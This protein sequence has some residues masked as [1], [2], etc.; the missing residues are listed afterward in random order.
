LPREAAFHYGRLRSLERCADLVLGVNIALGEQQLT[1]CPV[2]DDDGTGSVEVYELITGVN[3]ALSGCP[4]AALRRPS[5]SSTVALSDDESV[6]VMA[7][8]DGDAVSI[9]NTSDNTKIATVP[10]GNEPSSVVILPDNS[11]ALVANRAD[12]TV[13]VVSNIKSASAAVTATVDVGSEPTGLALSPTGTRVF[14]AEWAEGRVSVLDTRDLSTIATIDSPEHPRGLVVTNDGDT[15]DVD[16]T[17]IVSEFFGAVNP[18]IAGCPTNNAEGCDTGRTG[19]LRRFNVGNYQ[20]Q[21]AIGLQPFDSGFVPAGSAAGTPTVQTAPN[22]L[23]GLAILGSKVFVTSVSA[24]PQGPIN[25][26]ANVFPVV[27]A[28]NL[29]TGEEDRGIAGT[30]NLAKVAEDTIQPAVTG[31]K[32][33][34]LGDIVDL[35]FLTGSTTAYVVSRAADVLQ[36]VNYTGEGITIGTPAR[37]Q[38][39]LAA[40][41]GPP[42]CQN[43]TGVVTS[44]TLAKAF[45]NCWITRR[46]AVIDLANQTVAATIQSTVLPAAESLADQQRRGA[47]FF[48]TGRGR[49]SRNGDGYSACSSCHPDGLT[50]NITWAFGAGPR[51]TTSMDGSFS[52]GG[53]VQKQRIFNWTGIF[54]ELHDF[55]RNTRSVSGG[56]GAV[57]T[58][59]TDMCGDITQEQPVDV[60]GDGLGNSVKEIQDTTPDVCVKDFD[61]IDEFVK[62][63]RPPRALRTLDPEAVERGKQIFGGVGACHTCHGG[64]GWTV[65][66][67]FFEPSAANNA[68]LKS[69][70]FTAPNDAAFF[71]DHPNQIA[72]QP[73]DNDNTGANVPPN[74]VACVLRKVNTFGIPGDTTGTDTLEKKVDGSRAQG[75]G[76]FNVPSLYGLAV[77][78]PYLHHGQARTLHDVFSDSRWTAHLQ[79]GNAEFNPSADDIDDLVSFLL[80]IDAEAVEFTVPAGQDACPGVFPAPATPEALRQSIPVHDPAPGLQ[81]EFTFVGRVEGSDALIA[82]VSNGLAAVA[83]VCDGDQISEW[84]LGTPSGDSLQLAGEKGGSLNAVVGSSGISGTVSAGGTKTFS[85]VPAEERENGTY[86]SVEE[87]EEETTVA[88]WIFFDGELRGAVEDS[89]RSILETVRLSG[90]DEATGSGTGVGPGS[91]PLAD[92]FRCGQ[93]WCALENEKCFFLDLKSQI[94]SGKLKGQTLKMAQTMLAASQRRITADGNALTKNNCVGTSSCPSTGYDNAQD[95]PNCG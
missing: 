31:D 63:I 52:H 21:T 54:D 45:V 20:E 70:A 36:R 34:F 38:I 56:I 35:E 92:E 8:F 58:S 4:V 71:P 44:A 80:S 26:Q 79:A 28:A 12:A 2:F 61:D 17:L 15:D 74:Q 94:D 76:G 55:E 10:T 30:V 78:A 1:V 82:V 57:T 65:S 67:R 53:D 6:V 95:P 37:R 11:T 50:D 5:R 93:T 87:E 41:S 90:I 27:Y 62:T 22:Q 75:N 72:P 9:F 48:F 25:F 32:R 89:S 59:S 46:L 81:A 47:R 40:T 73:A 49:W 19:R 88:A 3:N 13:V 86:R 43:P 23:G 33:F 91:E 77:G 51:Q 66:R 14:V 85:T 83:Y 42:A 68:A 69:T 84:F 64:Q 39:D 60:G 16:E 7:D 24:S 18:N 29:T